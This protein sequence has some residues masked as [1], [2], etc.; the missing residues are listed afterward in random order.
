[1]YFI[2]KANLNGLFEK[3]AESSSVYMPIKKAD[4]VNFY[5]W[6]NGLEYCED[7]LKTVKSAKDLFFPQTENIVSFKKEGKKISVDAGELPTE[8]TVLFGVRACDAKS[9]TILDNVFLSEPADRF[10]KAR[11]ENGVVIT[12]ACSAP[13][14]TCFCGVFGIDPSNPG[15]DIQTW[16]VGDKLYWEAITEKGASFTEEFASL[17]T[18]CDSAEVDEEKAKITEIRKQLPLNSLSLEGWG[19]DKTEEKFDAPE[20]AELSQ[21]CLGCGAC[22]FVCP[23]C[24]CYDVRDYDSGHGVKRYR[25]WDSCM[26]SDFTMC[27]H[28]TNRPTQLQRFRQRFMHKLV[29]YPANNNGEFSC[30]GCGRCVSK[31]PISMNI[32]KVIKTFGGDNK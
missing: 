5:K 16:F 14:E 6:E 20:W 3:I 15:A 25:C 22:T 2:E 8:R 24:Q 21:A 11:R 7:A 30:V 19:G 26:F 28:G 23:T 18:S 31:C 17:L 13:E 27:A 10:Y 4:Q 32:A 29:Y 9:F 1:M 12:T